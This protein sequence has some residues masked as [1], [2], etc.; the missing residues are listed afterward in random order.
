MTKTYL[1]KLLTMLESEDT[2][3]DNRDFLDIDDIESIKELNSSPET[4]SEAL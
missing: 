4:P 1:E 3:Y 2:D